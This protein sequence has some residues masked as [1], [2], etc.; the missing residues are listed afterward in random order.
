MAKYSNEPFLERQLDR[1]SKQTGYFLVRLF[2]IPCRQLEP[3]DRDLGVAAVAHCA[4]PMN[5][6][7]RSQIF[8]AA[9]HVRS[10]PPVEPVWKGSAR[11]GRAQRF[12]RSNMARSGL[13]QSF[14][15]IGLG[16]DS[17]VA[18]PV[19]QIPSVCVDQRVDFH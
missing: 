11:A 1:L 12:W 18:A 10:S 5:L 16:P 4:V 3:E 15:P 17:L 2:H 19:A 7:G 14:P 8:P 13:C 9:L 6:V